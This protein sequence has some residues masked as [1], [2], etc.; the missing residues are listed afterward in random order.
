M[1]YEA[2]VAETVG[3]FSIG[4]TP[5][6]ADACLIPQLFNADRFKVDLS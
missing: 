3:K 1:T 6:A 4:D 5:T 2:Q